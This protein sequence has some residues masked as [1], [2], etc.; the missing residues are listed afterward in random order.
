MTT[1]SYIIRGGIPGRERL[2]VIARVM[3]PTT[4]SLFDRLDIAP[5]SRCLDAGCGGGD[6][7]CALAARVP[8]GVVVGVD[9]DGTEL[10]VAR[11]EAADRDLNHVEFRQADITAT[12]PDSDRGVYDLVYARFLLTHLT[13]PAAT[14]RQLVERLVPGGVLVVEDIDFRGHFCH[15]QSPAFER[16]LDWYQRAA[17]AR[18]VDPNIGPRLP[19]LLRESGLAGVAMN[20]V[21]PAGFAGE[22]KLSAPITL[23]AI[24]DAVLA[25]DL[26]NLEELEQTVDELYDFARRDDTV[27]SLPRIVQTWG[28]RGSG[29]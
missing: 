11:A 22:A 4:E 24:A 17:E 9:L 5:D 12:A 15:P 18:G 27:V 14:L 23:E 13:D 8:E 28:Y 19:G 25:N 21:Q 20:V 2:R 29:E 7:T 16:Y 10:E 1:P 6:V 3:S 26:C